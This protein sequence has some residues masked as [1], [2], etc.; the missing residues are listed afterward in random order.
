MTLP[1][2]SSP[3][4]KLGY[5][6]GSETIKQRCEYDADFEDGCVTTSG[7]GVS[8]ESCFCSTN[9]CNYNA[10]TMLN[11]FATTTTSTTTTTTNNNNKSPTTTKVTTT[12]PTTTTT[13]NSENS[14]N[15]SAFLGVTLDLFCI[16]I[17]IYHLK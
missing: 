7:G 10:T 11:G 4:L 3:T 5:D 17:I 6:S 9:L 14:D 13:H 15:S 8:V 16:L 1:E 12:T 2:F